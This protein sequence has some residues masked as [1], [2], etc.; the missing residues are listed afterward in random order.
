[1]QKDTPP[2]FEKAEAW[3]VFLVFARHA[4]HIFSSAQSA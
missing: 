3:A 2:Q 4:V 1:L